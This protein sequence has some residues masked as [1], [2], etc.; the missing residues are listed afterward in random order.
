ME[1]RTG[2]GRTGSRRSYFEVPGERK[3]GGLLGGRKS[4]GHEGATVDNRHKSNAFDCCEEEAERTKA[5]RKI[6]GRRK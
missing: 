3:E 5:R 2:L 1:I 4:W 6:P